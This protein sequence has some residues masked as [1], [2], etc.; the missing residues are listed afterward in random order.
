MKRLIFIFLLPLATGAFGAAQLYRWVDEKGNVEYRDTPP[1]KSAK[2]VEERKIVTSTI[3]TSAP[4]YAM[5][6]AIKNFP[7]TLWA[8]DCGDP[9]A[10]A[11]AHLAK[12]GVPY[13][14]KDPKA[15]LKAFEKL[16]GGDGV[17]VLFVGSTKVTGYHDGSWDNALD[18]AGYPRNAA[19]LKP[20]AKP[21]A[22]PDT[23]KKAAPTEQQAAAPTPPAEGQAQAAPPPPQQPDARPGLPG[24]K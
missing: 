12:R 22:K 24:R 7:V 21:A 4:S 11:R 20:A 8:Y 17:P 18:A 10:N 13:A 23:A 16:T 1:P 6:Q 15:D 19:P 3:E 14:E 2:K 5:Q 9:C